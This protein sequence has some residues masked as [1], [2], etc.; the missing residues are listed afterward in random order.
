MTTIVAIINCDYSEK[1]VVENINEIN[2]LSPLAGFAEAL[3]K[4]ASYYA[5][6]HQY[7]IYLDCISTGEL[8]TYK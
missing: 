7:F 4:I 6:I 3:S 1:S 8:L 2:E 5:Y